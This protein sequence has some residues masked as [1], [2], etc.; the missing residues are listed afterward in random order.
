MKFFISL[1]IFICFSNTSIT[2]NPPKD[3]D[4]LKFDI[5]H[6]DRDNT[7][8]GKLQVKTVFKFDP[9]TSSVVDEV[10][11]DVKPLPFDATQLPSYEWLEDYPEMLKTWEEKKLPPL[12]GR[13]CKWKI[14]EP[15]DT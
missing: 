1:L 6:F 8:S 4:E 13:A 14:V 5:K 10:N 15:S 2:A 11:F 7:P 3:F 9:K 12:P